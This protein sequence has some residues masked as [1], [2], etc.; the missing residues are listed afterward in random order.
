MSTNRRDFLKK[1]A[2]GSVG[3]AFTGGITNISAKSY[4][5]IIGSNDRLQIAIQGL[6]SSQRK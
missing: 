5:R 6:G 3:L 2:I 1:A 4:S